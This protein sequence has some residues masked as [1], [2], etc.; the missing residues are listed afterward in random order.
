MFHVNFVKLKDIFCKYFGIT[1]T[2][3][4]HFQKNG[5]LL[6]KIQNSFHLN[7]HLP[8]AE[9]G[10]VP[11]GKKNHPEK[12]KCI[13][14]KSQLMLGG[15]LRKQRVYFFYL[16]VILI[17]VGRT[18]KQNKKNSKTLGWDFLLNSI[19]SV[20]DDLLWTWHQSDSFK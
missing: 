20:M 3:S 4:R 2:Q 11:L 13:H 10:I 9:T 8:N 14:I 7:S 12:I 19:H 6:G 1:E 16:P 18:K 15:K 5:L 17:W